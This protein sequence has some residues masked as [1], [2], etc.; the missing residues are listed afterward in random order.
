[1][2]R[3]AVGKGAWIGEIADRQADFVQPLRADL[4]DE[5]LASL[6]LFLDLF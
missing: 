3:A 2:V 4:V 6:G 1:M 5:I